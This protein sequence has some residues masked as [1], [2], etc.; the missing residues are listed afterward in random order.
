MPVSHLLSLCDVF[1][2]QI[3]NQPATTISIFFSAKKER[4]VQREQNL[5]I[6]LKPLLFLK[7]LFPKMCIFYIN[8][9]TFS[10]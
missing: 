5:N 6:F 3:N 8:T 4:G 10:P 9:R 1:P 2:F 7:Y